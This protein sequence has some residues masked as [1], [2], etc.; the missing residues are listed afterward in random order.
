MAL[1]LV[2]PD[3]GAQAAVEAALEL[4]S[5]APERANVGYSS[6]WRVAALLEAADREPCADERYAPSPRSTRGATRA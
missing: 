3:G 1:E 6:P 4:A 2:P 5:V